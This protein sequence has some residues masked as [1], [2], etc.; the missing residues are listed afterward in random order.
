MA[1]TTPSDPQVNEQINELIS[2]L[3]HSPLLISLAA[4]TTRLYSYFY[5][6]TNG[7]TDHKQLINDYR[8]MVKESRD[9]HVTNRLTELYI[10]A[11]CAVDNNFVHS[12]D[13]LSSCDLG[14]LVP[15]SAVS[16]HLKNS[17]Y[18]LPPVSTTA[19]PLED[20]PTTGTPTNLVTTP[21]SYL[22][23]I[24]SKLPFM[25]GENNQSFSIPNQPPP[26]VIVN[27][28]LSSLLLSP[29]VQTYTRYNMDLLSVHSACRASFV[30]HFLKYTVPR[31]EE[32]H[33][34]TSR[35]H[36]NETAWFKKF[37]SFDP[38][39]AMTKF[40]SSL[41]GLKE[42][43][44]LNEE[45]FNL[46]VPQSTT[47]YLEYVHMISHNHRVTQTLSNETKY[48]SRDPEDIAMRG[49][50]R[51]HLL[52]LLSNQLAERDQLRCQTSLL[53][54]ESALGRNDDIFTKYNALMDKARESFGS[55]H[56]ELGNIMTSLAEL[57][58]YSGRYREAKTL[59]FDA[60]KIQE[61]IDE[62][63]KTSTHNLD[64]ATSLSLLGLVYSA[65]GEKQKCKDTLEKSLLLF[66][67]IPADGEIPKKQRKL[68]STTVTDL[69]HAYLFTGDVIG[70]KRYL[71][72]AIIAQRNIYGSDDH[73]EVARTLNVLSI[74]Y[75][76]LGDNIES[77]NFRSEAGKYSQSY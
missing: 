74:V 5:Q 12:I 1:N 34:K 55:T 19:S 57:Y 42:G 66:Q 36:W 49:Y 32:E 23:L 69:G 53:S 50:L 21:P 51:P 65:L 41:P 44:V 11:L 60:L 29:F 76:L 13:F 70:A 4:L 10:E 38:S 2:F 54:V 59:L 45:Q 22:S 35:V 39:S 26:S 56:F 33:L 18:K 20:T 25:G 62:R 77:R 58:Y 47:S 3:N 9:S 40:R 14:H 8:D 48:M 24:K 7:I 46:L 37:R 64:I 30:G 28:S 16:S 63:D 15:S 52:A 17:F 71:D 73:H 68:V 72:L 67:T 43:N 61:G 75:A 27:Y 31:I 6:T